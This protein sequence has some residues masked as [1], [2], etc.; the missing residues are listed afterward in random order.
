MVSAYVSASMTNEKLR[1]T[2][3]TYFGRPS[4]WLIYSTTDDEDL[5]RVWLEVE[6]VDLKEFIERSKA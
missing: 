3:F 6:S 2:R 5:K 1:K 4:P